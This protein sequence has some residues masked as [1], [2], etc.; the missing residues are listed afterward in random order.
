MAERLAARVTSSARTVHGGTNTARF[1]DTRCV[2]F[3]GCL[4]PLPEHAREAQ[5]SFQYGVFARQAG[6]D[7]RCFLLCPVWRIHLSRL[8]LAAGGL[9]G[10]RWPSTASG[11]GATVPF[12]LMTGYIAWALYWGI[13]AFWRRWRRSCSHALKVAS[14]LPGGCLL[15]AAIAFAVLLAGGY[16]FSVFGGGIYQFALCCRAAKYH[17]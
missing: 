6:P 13:P 17:L 1:A 2:S 14:F 9:W 8:A 11:L 15:Q 4:A 5:Q 7:W 10:T 12:A 16:F 3:F